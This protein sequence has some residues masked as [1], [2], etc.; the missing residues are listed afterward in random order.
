VK[1]GIRKLLNTKL[2]DGDPYL[3]TNNVEKNVVKISSFI[4]PKAS[5]NVI[6]LNDYTDRIKVVRGD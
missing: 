6:S 5:D 3:N 2:K 1:T 4:S